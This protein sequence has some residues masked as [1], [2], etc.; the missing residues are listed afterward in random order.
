M[1]NKI[2]AVLLWMVWMVTASYAQKDNCIYVPDI[3]AGW[4][5]TVAMPVNMD[6]KAEVVAVQFTLT[7]PDGVTIYP[8]QVVK[9]NRLG[10]HTVS[11][12]EVA[13]G[14]YTFVILSGDNEPIRG[15]TGSLMTVGMKICDGLSDGSV[16]PMAISDAVM[17]IRSGENILQTATAGNITVAHSTDF[18][19]K[20]V[21]LSQSASVSPGD[22]VTVSWVVEN[23]GEQ[24]SEG[25]W[26]E[27][28]MLVGGKNGVERL[29]T[30][31]YNDSKSLG[32]NAAIS[33]TAS[34]RLPQVLSLDGDAYIRVRL[35]PNSDSGE[36]VEVQ[37]NNT[38]DS[39]TK[40]RVNKILSLILPTYR[41]DEGIGKPI[42][43]MLQ[44]SG[45]W[46]EDETFSIAING[47]N[48]IQAPSSVTIPALQSAVS[49]QLT[50]ADNDVL[51]NDSI[52]TILFEGNGYDKVSSKIV[53]E[54]NEYP[55]LGI[56]SSK[57]VITEGESFQLTVSLS[58]PSPN[59]ISVTLTSENN[60][61]FKYP[62]KVTIP[63][64]E[65]SVVVDVTTVDDELPSLE[66]SNA[67]TV[68]A[69]KY[70]KGEVIVLLKDNDL[71]VLELQLTPNKVSESVGVVAVAGVLR[72]TTNTN[73][74]ITVKL[75]DDADGGL[76][77]GNRTIELAKGV[78]EVHFN[79]G[80]VDNA[81]VDGDRIYTITASVWLSSCSCSAAGEAAG[82]V[83]AQLSVLD[84]D[85]PALNL[86][87]S[88]STVKEGGTTT[89]TISRNTTDISKPLSVS[90]SSDYDDGLLYAHTATIPA[91]QASTNVEITSMGNNTQGDSHMVVF[92]VKAD[93]Y[94]S[95]T[96][97]VIVTD[98]T[99]PDAVITS[100]STNKNETEAGA[101]ISVNVVVAN[102]G[103]S[104][105]PA[106][107][108]IS[109]YANTFQRII[110]TDKPLGIGE[111]AILTIPVAM[112]LTIGDVCCYAIINERR[113]EAEL[114]YCNNT[115]SNAIVTTVAPFKAMLTTDKSIYNQGEHIMISGSIACQT[116][117]EQTVEVYF[118]SNG[119][120]FVQT[121]K[122]D[123][124]GHFAMEWIPYQGMCGTISVGACYEGD[125]L[126]EEMA[127]ISIVGLRLQDNAP[128]LLQP[129]VDETIKGEFLINNPVGFKQTGLSV[130]I[131]EQPSNYEINFE[132]DSDVE[133]ES[134]AIIK[135]SI[136]PL[137]ATQGTEWEKVILRVVSNEGSTTDMI[138]RVYA[139]NAFA[140]LQSSE[141][142]IK[143]NATKG[144]I[145][146]FALTVT[147]TGNGETG[148]I[149]LSLP[150]WMTCA[151]GNVLPS[152]EKNGT[153]NILLQISPTEEM[154]LNIPRTGV[155][156]IN[157]QNGNGVGIEYDITPVESS[158]GVLIVD[159]VDT[160]TYN[161]IEAPHVSGAKV[162]L[163]LPVTE[164][165]VTTGITD[166]EG[167][168]TASLPAGYYQLKI[169]TDKHDPYSRE[170]YVAPE[171]DNKVLAILQY[172][173]IK[174]SWSVKETEIKDEYDIVS[175]IEYETN[176][177]MPVI[178]LD[179]PERVGADQLAEGES[180][181]FNAIITNKGLIAGKNTSLLFSEHPLF[182][183]ETL[184]KDRELTIAPQQSIVIP[185]KVT[186]RKTD[187]SKVRRSIIIG[188]IEVDCGIKVETLSYY[189][190][191][192][193]GQWYICQKTIMYFGCDITD[194]NRFPVP[195]FPERKKIIIDPPLPP[196]I[197]VV[198]KKEIIIDPPP[199][200]AYTG[201]EP[202][203]N[204]KL[205]KIGEFGT[206]FIPYFSAPAG[207]A[208]CAGDYYDGKQ[209]ARHYINCA[210]T[211]ASIGQH[212]ISETAGKKILIL[213]VINHLY[214]YSEPCNLGKKEEKGANRALGISY[215]TDFENKLQIP[216]AELEAYRDYLMEI[217]GNE[218]LAEETDYTSQ[219]K[220]LDGVLALNDE[221]YQF[222]KLAP[223]KPDNVSEALFFSFVERLN[224]TTLF[225][226]GMK[227]DGDN[228]IHYDVINSCIERIYDSEQKSKLLGYLSTEDMLTKE[229]NLVLSKLN[230]A[231]NSICASISL[232]FSQTMSLARPAYR[233]T[234]T[235]FN[236]NE[237]TA[238]TDVRLNLE[239]KDEDGNIATAH[240]FQINA[241]SLDGFEGKTSLPGGWTLDAK[242]T[243][244]ATVLFI[245]TK[246]AAPTMEKVYSFGGTLTYIDP[247]TELEVSRRLI[248]TSLTVRPLPELELTYLMQRDVY[249]DDPLTTE[250][251]E[252]KQP[253]EFALIIN[254][255][256]YGEAKNVRML[257]EKPNI[258]DNEKGLFG[259]FDIKSS[260]LNGSA[261]NLSFGQTIANNFGTI[262]AQSQAYAQW[263]LESS[264][265]G[266][267]T[268]YEVEAKHV[269]SYGNADLSLLDTVTIHEMIHGFTV[270]NVENKP[271]RGYLVNDI[272][273]ADD[274]PDIVYFTDA[275]KQELFIVS[276]AE[277]SRIN[278]IE[279]L[280]KVKPSQTGWN[281]GS[282]LDPTYGKQ[283]LVKVIRAD[284]ME[285]NLDNVWQTDRTLRD[286]KDWLYENQLHFV[287]N[288]SAE[289]ETF[290]LTF[291]PR[292][293]VELEVASINGVPEEGKVLKEPLKSVTVIFN[294][295]IDA[296]TF[297]REDISLICQGVHVE[298]PIAITAKSD[299]QFELNLS[300]ATDD[301]G[302]YVLTVQT[303]GIT[304]TDGFKGAVGKSAS[305][306]QYDV[307]PSSMIAFADAKVKALCVEN[308][309]T[310]N[311][312]ELSKS[313]A[314]A[315]TNLANVF[316]G[317]SEIT[318]FNELQY[319]TGLTSIGGY[320]FFNCRSLTSIIIPKSVTSIGYD[321]FRGCTDL[322]SIVVEGENP[323]YDSREGCNAIIE[324]ATNTLVVGCQRTVI[325]SGVTTIGDRAF[326]DCGKMKSIIIP[327]SVTTIGDRA[328][329][330]CYALASL[331]IPESV[332]RIDDAAFEDCFD[333]ASII[334]EDGNQVFD[335]RN[336][337]NAVIET[338]TNTLV[339]GC[340]NTIIP[341]E[342][343]SIGNNAFHGCY[344]LKYI[345]IP[346]GVT[347]IGH[348]AF[349]F[350]CGLVAVKMNNPIPPSI[351]EDAFVSIE[352][353][354][355]LYV[356]MGSKANYEAAKYWNSLKEIIE[357]DNATGIKGVDGQWIS[358]ENQYD[359]LGRPISTIKRGV[360]IKKGKKILVK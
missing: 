163:L 219:Q 318:S 23:I 104:V 39:Q 338:A 185:V 345:S 299:T 213:N 272:V 188:G 172:E 225:A 140:T 350:R 81:Q 321:A 137:S 98:Q 26:H 6:N 149:T 265:L 344:N 251:V 348:W 262:P 209:D 106:G 208:S 211:F 293:E 200:F 244:T 334:V 58:R 134:N 42:Q 173:P 111:S 315:V 171:A 93:N 28:L 347:N 359:L 245:P 353:N 138:I 66:L 232:Q 153:M 96:C 360:Y 34:I 116:D 168:Y 21:T 31:I 257:T 190:C 235:V 234:L 63:A 231:S 99:L 12:R 41:I 256:G 83:A 130:Q 160:Y 264:L 176:V 266:H 263:W 84:N 314:A 356:P 343:T 82:S 195:Y 329:S 249:G 247:F 192:V 127:A 38:A 76:Y 85:G 279:Y 59:P 253:V 167:L 357:Y 242:Q 226:N 132:V 142:H 324:T 341:D 194:H 273:D 340:Q 282:I 95:G 86:I 24:S 35:I 358:Y 252:Q 355:T 29:L 56:T 89:L 326:F 207:V 179:V 71:P 135:Y 90:I 124:E 44:R 40:L 61:R 320:A 123:K 141:R 332:I 303:A 169:T 103:V 120:R 276:S 202:C 32:P 37:G 196:Y 325:P 339:V 316:E 105:L 217:F 164:K 243:G 87:S 70:N 297:T 277:I 136:K 27:Q 214:Q 236:G 1:R 181:I 271:L 67:F 313:E 49:F 45:S 205:L 64:G 309:D 301:N 152:L 156:A 72:R 147:N 143:T 228:Y 8:D 322:T 51:D 239:V 110:R 46:E 285:V 187:S 215:L 50:I 227:I 220:L 118:I 150:N 75:S 170:V 113:I 79:F 53:I 133:P 17:S 97:Y 298:A 36:R 259:D 48:R 352:S 224:N 258:I 91:G 174:V 319:F 69:L 270:K 177:P 336:G 269:T 13:T 216:I 312:G 125:N 159:V 178:V 102:T 128:I 109:L 117:M 73:S 267:F 311:D 148:K 210:N 155:L 19:V 305:W 10:N 255:K 292:S 328:F 5:R 25:G 54:D 88:V 275:Q 112:P 230:E 18:I 223:Y 268:S 52:A 121:T 144:Q 323:K 100:I 222:E 197:N 166:A 119:N 333:L 108:E 302:Y 145:T 237:D 233:G 162:E 229:F 129:M 274:L 294:K 22:E 289:G 206:S 284:G 74:K 60:K 199:P 11:V 254:N 68:S 101:D 189:D 2:V 30:T 212:A 7:V 186:R 55:S 198:T 330:A 203:Q 201:C 351:N 184:A 221:Y 250:V 290:Y 158:R 131:L 306:I 92:T 295:A 165:T 126:C 261:A 193:D 248:P 308:W 3:K 146:N 241:E 157:C 4:G 327:N 14:K 331:T 151:M 139:R 354:V 286:G 180:L 65:S 238:M 33:R 114:N 154:P 296:Q 335:S 280:L 288:M 80:P 346:S 300:N 15:Y 43:A 287:G 175:T 260:Q 218:A 183:I 94:A 115:S 62:T 161:T 78:E 9:S 240:E 57:S 47:D 20:D 122:S 191:G 283:K 310:N 291:E 107:I 342:V 317:N 349:G 304:D 204:T 182:T 281:Y 16:S 307:E 278:N 77:F 337:C 246:Y